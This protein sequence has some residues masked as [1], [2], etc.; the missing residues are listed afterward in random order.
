MHR[1]HY[2]AEPCQCADHM[3]YVPGEVADH[4]DVLAQ[5]L[6]HGLVLRVVDDFLY[7]R[8]EGLGVLHVRVSRAVQHQLPRLTNKW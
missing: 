7:P 8:A 6:E 1:P 4:G 5:V 2:G 3:P